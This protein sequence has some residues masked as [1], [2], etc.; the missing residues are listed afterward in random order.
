MI[1]PFRN[2]FKQ[3]S[4]RLQTY[5]CRLNPLQKLKPSLTESLKVAAYTSSAFLAGVIAKK[6]LDDPDN[7]LAIKKV[8]ALGNSSLRNQFNFIGHVVKK[9]APGVVYIEIQDPKRIDPETNDSLIISNGSGFVI[10]SDGWIL[11]NAHVVINKPKS[12]ITVKMHNGSV[13]QATVE[14]ADMNI[15]LALIKINSPEPLPTLQFAKP[16]DL[17]V[18]EWVVALGSP[19]SLSHSVTAG[20]ISSVNR[21]A[22]EL[23]LRNHSMQYI[24]TD[25]SITFGNSGGP[26]V[27]LDGDVIG[28][29]NLRI[30]AGISFAI[31]IAYARKFLDNGKHPLSKNGGAKPIDL[32]KNLGMTT[33][34]ITAS[35]LDDVFEMQKFEGKKC[36]IQGVLIYKVVDNSLAYKSG[37]LAG[38]II[39]RVDGVTVQTAGDIYSK[40]D[41]NRKITLELLRNG[42]P[43]EV[44]MDIGCIKDL[45]IL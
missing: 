39:T 23:G 33:L 1:N 43:I 24:Q 28:I 3:I 38:D 31:P 36:E 13:F 19:L 10:R 8:E 11:T 32:K 42:Q 7:F 27:N 15:D 26:L 29:N 35:I 30:T 9:C 44:T 18:G 2:G 21:A 6:I 5:R 14:D 34:P 41:G 17:T 40:I 20:I 37:L 25:A 22:S 16:D 12:L 4:K 45:P